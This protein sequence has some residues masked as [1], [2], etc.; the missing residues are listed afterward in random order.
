MD[1]RRMGVKNKYYLISKQ[2]MPKE[3]YLGKS[4]IGWLYSETHVVHQN[5]P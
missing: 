3:K 1:P 4:A 5:F 2:V